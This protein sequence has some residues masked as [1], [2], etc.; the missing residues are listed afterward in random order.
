M[1]T[2]AE[3]YQG[4][5][6]L[7]EGAETGVTTNWHDFFGGGGHRNVLKLDRGDDGII[8]PIY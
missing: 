6:E 3:A 2:D 5:P 4:L 7:R 1:S 8:R